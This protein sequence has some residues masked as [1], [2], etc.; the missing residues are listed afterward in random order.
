MINEPVNQRHMSDN[1]GASARMTTQSRPPGL[2]TKTAQRTSL[3]HRFQR[4]L[5]GGPNR[6]LPGLHPSPGGAASLSPFLNRRLGFPILAI[7]A[8]LAASLLFLL[9]GGLAHG[10]ED[11]PIEYAEND[12]GSVATFTATDPEGRPVVYWSLL[13]ANAADPSTDIDSETDSADAAH[14]SISANG[15]LSFKFS[16]DYEMPRGLALGTDNTYR[17]VV[18]AADEPLGAANRV[19]GYEEVTVSVTD[20]DERGVITLDAQQPQED[21]LLMATLID[22]DAS[23]TQ[24]MT[25]KWKWEHSE[26]KGGPWTAILTAT[27]ATYMPLGVADKYLRA[28]ATYTDGHGSDKNAQEVSAHMVRA[29]PDATNAAPVFTDEDTVAPDI[30]V[31]RKVDENS[32]PGTIV[33]EPVAAEDTLDDVLTYTLADDGDNDNYRINPATGQITVGPRTTLDHEANPSDTVTVTAT[34]PAGGETDQPVTITINDVNEVPV[35]TDGDTKESVV[36]NTAITEGVG[37][38]NYVAYPEVS[39]IA[40]T[41][42]ICDWSLD[43]TDAEDF[44]IGNQTPGT[45]GQLTFKETPNFEMPADANRDNEYMVTVVVTDKGIDGKGKLSAERD[46]VVTVTNV[47]EGMA[48]T[49][50]TLSSLQPQ[51]GIPLTATLDDPDGGEKD[52]EWQWSTTA[53]NTAEVPGTP[54]A[55]QAGDISG[56]TSD[57]YTPK[58]NDVGGTLTATVTYADVLDSGRTGMKAAANPVVQDLATAKAPV[59]KPK[60]TSR[61]VPENYADGDSYGTAPATYDYPNVGAVVTATDP[62]G[63]TMTYSLGGTDMGSFSIDEMSGQITV[64]D[65]TKLDRESKATYRVTVIATDPGNL[66]DSVNVTIKLT[67]KDEGPTIAGDDVS[68]DY[69][70]NG[71][72]SVATLSATDPEG[73]RPVYWTL[74]AATAADPSTDIDSETDS[75]DAAHFSISANGVLSFNFPPD[76]EAPPDS[77]ATDNTYKVVVIA[78]DEPQG[79]DNREL[80]YKE[81]TVNVTNVNETETVTLSRRQAQVDTELTATYNDSDKEMPDGTVLTWSWYLGGSEIP[82]AGTDT[83]LTS[84]YTPVGSGSLKAEASYTK[85]DG[86]KKLASATIT[87][88]ATPTPGNVA[89]VFPT[90]TTRRS[91]DENSPPGTTR[92]GEPVEANDTRGDVL[93]YTLA[94][95]GDNVNYRINPATGQITVGPQTALDFETNQSDT[96]TVTA[97]DPAGGTATQ[98]VTITINDVNEVPVITD[99]DTKESVV[100]NTAITE[101]VGTTNYVAYRRLVTSPAPKP[102]ATGPS[103]APTLRT[104]TLAIRPPAPRPVDLQ[105]NSQLRDACGRQ[106][107]QR[108]HGYRGGD[109][110]GHRRQGQAERRAGCGRYRHQR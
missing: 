110:Q 59:F 61:S 48:D 11:G 92:V 14:F 30:Q 89:P 76:Y 83:D 32:P 62:N 28:T 63:D 37:T 69:P 49:V 104:S 58:I 43:G 106:Q 6:R 75:A 17:V 47:N 77:N 33:G 93:T 105:G 103:R 79:A 56:A 36:E 68:R 19:L 35:I 64:K 57:T 40:C 53:A 78:A 80:G 74:L 91:V 60:P 99:G 15:V 44:N 67:D 90:A 39:D 97:T 109:R 27:T 87:V 71:M 95:D 2:A 50:V 45:P 94:A 100:E 20:E 98:E 34:D 26:S 102:Y 41:E 70:E 72:G 66:R 29:V 4:A 10:Q 5:A 12:T 96:V 52:I 13:A 85:E 65:A 46:V 54:A 82:N 3:G 81:V 51:V 8:L 9:P 24:K 23:E 18:V 31:G 42:T 86:S 101:G 21:I 108:V 7:L 22:D 55:T 84:T 88:R 16:P 73:R 1:P 38:T 107:G 25:A